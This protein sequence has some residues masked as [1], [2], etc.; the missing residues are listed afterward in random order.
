MGCH[1]IH[2]LGVPTSYS[3]LSPK[4]ISCLISEPISV[5]RTVLKYRANSNFMLSFNPST[6]VKIFSKDVSDGGEI[7]GVEVRNSNRYLITGY[8][9]NILSY[10]NYLRNIPIHS[11]SR[12]RENEVL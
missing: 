2:S 4:Y 5:G 7:W 11:S 6:P 10:S 3:G 8:Y 12:L 1:I 9:R